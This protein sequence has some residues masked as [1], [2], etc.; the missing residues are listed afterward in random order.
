MLHR[1]S[2]R[3]ALTLIELIIVIGGLLFLAALLLPIIA[4][5]RIAAG[6]ASSSN[7]LRQFGLA[8]HNY[9][10]SFGKMPPGMGQA[11]NADGPTHFHILPFIEQDN[12]FKLAEG[13]PWKNGTYGKVIPV[14]IDPADASA[15]PG[16]VYQSWLATTNYAA[17]WMVF[18]TGDK[19]LADIVDGTSNT[20]MTATRYQMCNGNPT[21][22]GYASL[23]H[24]APL[25]A[26]DSTAKFQI[27]P[28]QEECDP[29]VPQTL[30][31]TMLVGFCDGSV[32]NIEPT[33][34]PRTWYLLCD[35]ADGNVIENDF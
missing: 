4:R 29:T 31:T 2:P 9:H 8:V 15:P 23:Y 27:S 12:L 34:S 5:L 30:G 35:P 14:Y 7:N 20:L 32:R 3:F 1:Q 24:W 18:R 22:W 13:A 17:N 11:N 16:N 26:L 21:G 19:R 33:V 10:D 6:Q 25:F 28:K